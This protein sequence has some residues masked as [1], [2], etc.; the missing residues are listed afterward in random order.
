MPN[1]TYNCTPVDNHRKKIGVNQNFK[2]TKIRRDKVK[3]RHY[4]VEDK[5]YFVDYHSYRFVET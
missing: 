1:R 5:V 2:T 3:T 4:T